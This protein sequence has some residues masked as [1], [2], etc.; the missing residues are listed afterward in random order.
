V[1]R[2][3]GGQSNVRAIDRGEAPHASNRKIAGMRARTRPYYYFLLQRGEREQ[4]RR[5]RRVRI[6]Y[7]VSPVLVSRV[8]FSLYDRIRTHDAP[9]AFRAARPR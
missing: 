5:S 1:G 3:V 2:E 9:Q 7:P 8:F 6:D 4:R